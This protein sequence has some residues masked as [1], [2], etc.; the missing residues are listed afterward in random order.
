MKTPALSIT[1]SVISILRIKPRIFYCLSL[2]YS[3]PQAIAD[4]LS[5]ITVG[6]IALPLALALGVAS[7]PIYLAPPFLSPAIGIFT[8]IIGGLIVSLLGG[9]RVQGRIGQRHIRAHFDEAP[10][11]A[12]EILATP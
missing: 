6:L 12:R 7:I 2:G 10:I 11:R 1:S 5:G 3:R 4:A 9:S 8:A